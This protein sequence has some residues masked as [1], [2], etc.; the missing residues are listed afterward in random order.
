MQIY[1]DPGGEKYV[2]YVK[3]R[4]RLWHQQMRQWKVDL[5]NRRV[6]MGDGFTIYLKSLHIGNGQFADKAR[7][8]GSALEF[9]FQ[10]EWADPDPS[11]M[12]N[13]FYTVSSGGAVTDR[14]PNSYQHPDNASVEAT[15]LVG[16]ANGFYT[17]L[18]DGITTYQRAFSSSGAALG[19]RDVSP[20]SFV[21]N[22]A[23]R[24]SGGRL[25]SA[26]VDGSALIDVR[27]SDDDG[28]TWVASS[29]P[30]I[31]PSFGNMGRPMY[32]GGSVVALGVNTND[33]SIGHCLLSADNGET[34]V[35]QATFSV[36]IGIDSEAQVVGTGE[37]A[38]CVD[39]AIYVAGNVEVYL[40][41]DAGVTWQEISLFELL[42][43][44]FAETSFMLHYVLAVAPGVF[45]FYALGDAES[46]MFRTDDYFSSITEVSITNPAGVELEG[47]QGHVLCVAANVLVFL[48]ASGG[49]T[50]EVWKLD[51]STGVLTLLYTLT[52]VNEEFPTL[53]PVGRI[54][55][56]G[57][58][59]IYPHL[60]AVA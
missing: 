44:G 20:S 54:I 39:A 46:K 4:F 52:R 53:G 13:Y 18:S 9:V 55:A 56:T 50:N 37:G 48:T 3:Q 35:D 40:T 31:T 16:N 11:N 42:P 23:T 17:F 58:S 25:L 12:R 21:P 38:F 51:L 7:I 14:V 32:L 28:V 8:T 41:P 6:D 59:S 36:P 49:F 26:Y 34:F 43:I 19:Q 30:A 10:S 27:Y 60:P 24:I 57:G 5:I 2:G 33:G 22:F 29:L 15:S 1:A 45:V 47:S